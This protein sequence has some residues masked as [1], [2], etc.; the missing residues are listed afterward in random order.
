M[1]RA[2]AQERTPSLRFFAKLI[3]AFVGM[4]GLRLDET[5]PLG[6]FL[7]W[8]IVF[9]VCLLVYGQAF[10]WGDT[11]VDKLRPW[12][13]GYAAMAWMS[14]YIGL[15]VVLGTGLREWMIARWGPERTRQV[16]NA[17]MGIIFL[18]QG[19]AH[20][21]VY[22]VWPGTMGGLPRPVFA[23]AG[24]ALFLFG[25]GCK[26]WATYLASLDTY[27]Y[28]DMLLGRAGN[29][30]GER[31]LAGPYRWFKN[32]MYGVGNLQGYGSALIAASWQGLVV[33]AVFHAS[34]YCFYFMFERSFVARAYR[35]Q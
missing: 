34:I 29:A 14:Y 8:L 16:F 2:A 26:L 17:V 32:P 25:A 12:V 7:A 31:V 24:F 15:S 1:H 30:N 13:I 3:V 5:R 9:V 28:N 27:Y 19:L 4:L 21:A 33:T 35:P 11:P 18:N 23:A 20:G 22:E 6:L 10:I